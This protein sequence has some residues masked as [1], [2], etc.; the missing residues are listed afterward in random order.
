VIAFGQRSKYVNA[1]SQP[2]DSPFESLTMSPPRTTSPSSSTIL[3]VEDNDDLREVMQTVLENAGWSAVGVANGNEA[4]DYLSRRPP[5]CVIV[6]DLGLPSID[7]TT[8]RWMQLEVRQWARI[9]VIVCT[10]DCGAVAQRSL[11]GIAR[12]LCKPFTATELAAAVQPY[13]LAS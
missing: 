4:L 8:F 12:W 1:L 3:V 13:C 11:P 10:A 9:P 7:G 6:L 2:G 5:P